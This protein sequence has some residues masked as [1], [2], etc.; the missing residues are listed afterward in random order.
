MVWLVA[1]ELCSDSCEREL[2]SFSG[3]HLLLEVKCPADD[4]TSFHKTRVPLEAEEHFET[5][6]N[7]KNMETHIAFSMQG[8]DDSRWTETHQGLT[9]LRKSETKPKLQ[10]CREQSHSNSN[11]SRHAQCKNHLKLTGYSL[12]PFCLKCIDYVIR[13][14]LI[15]LPPTLKEF[16]R[17][18]FVL[19]Y[20]LQ[21]K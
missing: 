13:L 16:L 10:R 18:L 11:H 7:T 17:P 19:A 4:I 12:I 14:L 20:L 21:L 9:K 2:N 1:L 15:P 8:C 6:E 5:E 3:P